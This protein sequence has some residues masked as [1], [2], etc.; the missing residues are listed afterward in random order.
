M[1]NRVYETVRCPSVC[2]SQHGP[3]AANPLLQVFAAVGPVGKRYQAI[4]ARRANA[5]S[6]TLSAYVCI[7]ETQTSVVVYA[8]ALS[9]LTT[10]CSSSAIYSCA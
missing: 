2:L 3:T 4:A 10:G 8:A 6:V 1:R 7:A 9:L 5:G